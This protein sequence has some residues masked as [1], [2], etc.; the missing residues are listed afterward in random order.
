MSSEMSHPG[1]WRA[2]LAVARGTG[3]QHQGSGE[4]MTEKELQAS[5]TR[6]LQARA[7]GVVA[8]MSWAKQW[9]TQGQIERARQARI[10]SEDEPF[11]HG[12]DAHPELWEFLA[13]ITP[14]PGV[15]FSRDHF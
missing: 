5:V 6:M 14:P 8:G 1:P 7:S 4:A 11:D 2:F 15:V 10:E 12:P 9:A 13:G 3:N